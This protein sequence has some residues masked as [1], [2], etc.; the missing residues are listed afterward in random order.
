MTKKVAD[1]QGKLTIV[2]YPAV[3]IKCT[4]I[5]FVNIRNI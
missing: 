1:P 4:I 5:A 2:I 3:Q